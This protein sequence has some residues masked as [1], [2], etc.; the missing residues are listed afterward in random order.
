MKTYFINEKSQISRVELCHH[1]YSLKLSGPYSPLDAGFNTRLSE[2][3][4]IS[5]LTELLAKE[6][7]TDSIEAGALLVQEDVTCMKSSSKK[8]KKL[9]LEQL[10][11]YLVLAHMGRLWHD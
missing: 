7:G 10:F 6:Y 8:S 1:F 2:I 4:Q 3:I 5:D 11:P 9:L